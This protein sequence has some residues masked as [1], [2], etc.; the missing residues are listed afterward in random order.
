MTT[1]VS[2][3]LAGARPLH[4][5]SPL[6]RLL[7][8]AALAA[9]VTLVAWRTGDWW[10]AAAEAERIRNLTVVRVLL[11]LGL[12]AA[13]AALPGLL[14]RT[15]RVGALAFAGWCGWLGLWLL[16]QWPGIVVDDSMDMVQNASQGV[17]Y[18]WFSYLHSVYTLALFDLVPHVAAY[19][20]FQVA[21]T[22]G[23]FAYATQLVAARTRSRAP[24]VVMTL[25]L[26]LSMPVIVETI[27]YT[28]DTPFA[29]L[30]LLVALYV[31]H[32]VAV[33][34]G[35]SRGGLAGLAVLV[36]FLSAYRGDGMVLLVVVPV[37]LAL[38]LRPGRRALAG[39]AVAFAAAFALF[40]AVLP[41]LLVVR[42]SG[43]AYEMTLRLNPLGAVL[44]T[45]F[46]SPDKERDLREL[47]AVIDVEKVK[48]VQDATNV[49]GYWGG[50]WNREAPE[51]Q[52]EAFKA[53]S[54]RVLLNN[55]M[56]VLANR[57]STFLSSTSLAPGSLHGPEYV[58]DRAADRQLER[59]GDLAPYVTATPPVLR[60]YTPS[61]ET[62]RWATDFEGVGLSGRALHWNFLPWLL[63]LAACLLAPRRLRFEAVLAAIVLSRVPLVFLLSPVAQYKYYYSVHL[64]G[65]VVLGFLL[66]RVRAEQVRALVPA[67]A[68]R[69][70]AASPRPAVPA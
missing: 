42:D 46:Y 12:T 32:T 22:A 54:T 38:L 64:G 24:V 25:V 16:A 43:R 2:P 3:T 11:F 49:E 50:H 8:A 1:M 41:S 15:N 4:R 33:R 60:L 59:R 21:L 66:A 28:R 5:S 47:G 19:G 48:E 39:G 68:R 65:M 17:V 69:R 13:F 52:W 35:L 30:H 36:G 63:V 44:Q 61:L 70:P 62:I 10:S 29:V 14:R 58:T 7:A 51:P 37:L 67:W 26:A 57:T 40:H 55:P 18:D 34:C 31:A 53:A 56:T 45:D 27:Q 9:V 6:P 23:V 20:V